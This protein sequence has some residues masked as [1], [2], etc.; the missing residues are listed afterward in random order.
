M[1]PL[2]PIALFLALGLGLG[3]LYGRVLDP[4]E[5]VDTVPTSLRADYRTDYVLM[6]AE[7]YHADHDIELARRRLSIMGS[8]TPS[9]LCE[10]ALAFA[11]AAGYPWQDRQL[12]AEM[13]RAVQPPGFSASPAA[14]EP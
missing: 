3:L 9:V 6:V 1:R 10:E 13:A 8:Q 14:G 2:M 12:L 4:V 7:R 5:I 11:D